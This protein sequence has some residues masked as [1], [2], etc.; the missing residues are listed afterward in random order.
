MPTTPTCLATSLPTPQFY[1]MLPLTDH[2]PRKAF[3][4]FLHPLILLYLFFAIL[5][6]R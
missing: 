5:F 1:T 6:L 2:L 3:R 4:M